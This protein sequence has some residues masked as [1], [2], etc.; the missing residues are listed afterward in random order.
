MS[1]CSKLSNLLL[2]LIIIFPIYLSAQTPIMAITCKRGSRALI[3]QTDGPRIIERVNELYQKPQLQIQ[4]GL[5]SYGSECP[6][7]AGFTCESI[8]EGIN[9]CVPSGDCLVCPDIEGDSGT[10]LWDDDLQ[11]YACRYIS[12]P[13]SGPVVVFAEAPDFETGCGCDAVIGTVL[14]DVV[15]NGETITTCAF[16]QCYNGGFSDPVYDCSGFTNNV[17][18]VTICDIPPG[19]FLTIEDVDNCE[20]LNPTFASLFAVTNGNSEDVGLGPANAMGCITFDLDIADPSV[21][22]TISFDGPDLNIDP[23]TCAPLPPPDVPL[24]LN[25]SINDP[26]TCSSPFNPASGLYTDRLIVSGLTPNQNITLTKNTEGFK[27]IFGNPLVINTTTMMANAAGIVSFTF[28]KLEGETTNIEL[29]IPQPGLLPSLVEPFVASAPCPLQADC[30]KLVPTLGQWGLI[31][32]SL[33]LLIFGVTK[34]KE[35][36]TI[37]IH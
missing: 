17:I 33:I 23:N 18:K 14:T 21:M 36:E 34:I 25:V 20:F 28:Y 16:P 27:D 6:C 37:T 15:I 19:R 26:C 8:D 13:A 30:P 5:K 2:I 24:S 11:A 29:T 3:Q 32:L 12:G 9:I 22:A 10:L 31:S 1:H 4:E 35:L 7:P